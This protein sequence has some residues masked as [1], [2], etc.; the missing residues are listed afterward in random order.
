MLPIPADELIF[1]GISLGYPD[2][3]HPINRFAT[4]LPANPEVFD[5]PAP[6][7]DRWIDGMFRYLRRS[8]RRTFRVSLIVDR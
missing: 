5:E 6:L 3:D 7:V 4:E 1:C 8:L 2:S